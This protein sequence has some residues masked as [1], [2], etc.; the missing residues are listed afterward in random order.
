MPRSALKKK[1]KIKCYFITGATSGLDYQ[2]DEPLFS[3]Q[4]GCGERAR[5]PT[6]T[7]TP[8]PLCIPAAA[9]RGPDPARGGGS[10]GGGGFG[11]TPGGE[12]PDGLAKPFAGGLLNSPQPRLFNQ[13][14]ANRDVCASGRVIPIIWKLFCSRCRPGPSAVLLLQGEKP[15]RT[16][17]TTRKRRGAKVS[18][19]FSLIAA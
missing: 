12:T 17:P 19:V 11:G 4:A 3:H 9:P 15:R 7:P 5:L 8:A 1:K 13:L 16:S 2:P 10:G 18:D 6:G 14:L